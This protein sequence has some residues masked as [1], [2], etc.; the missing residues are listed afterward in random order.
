MDDLTIARALHVLSLV[1]WIGGVS[2]VTLVL[3]PGLI[4]TVPAA[5]RLVLFEM[6]EGR[7]A[8]QARISTVI[9]GASGFWMTDRLA[10][11][12]RFVDSH[13]WWM[14]AMVAVWA[15]FTFVLFVAEP[16]FLHRWFHRRMLVDPEG[17]FAVVRIGHWALL[18]LS[19]VTVGG[20]LPIGLAH[21]IRLKANVAAGSV[22]RWS[23][24]ELNDGDETLAA[25]REMET[26]FGAAR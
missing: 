8:R 1:H 19:L 20:A 24:V 4:R 10:A 17:T 6:I 25:R 16:L 5:Q 21:N 18:T 3:L 9:A 14:H 2:M 15:I 13:F 7:F 11:W 23:D 26:R 12:D 22:L